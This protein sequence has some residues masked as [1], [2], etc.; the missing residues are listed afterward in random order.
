M[1]KRIISFD[2]ACRKY[3]HRFTFEHMPQWAM[4]PLDGTE[5]YYAPQY[6]SDSTW[7]D[8][9]LFPGESALACNGFCYST[10]QQW[11]LGKWLAAPFNPHGQNRRYAQEAFTHYEL[12]PTYDNLSGKQMC[13]WTLYG[14]IIDEGRKELVKVVASFKDLDEAKTMALR[15]GIAPEIIDE[16]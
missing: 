6:A 2:E 13:R 11:P 15:L 10:A 8:R 4:K 1:T 12:R 9:T 3:V 7:Y 5:K 16:A 14:L